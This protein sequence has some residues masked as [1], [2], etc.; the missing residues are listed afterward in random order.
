M[1]FTYNQID[2]A[3]C[4]FEAVPAG[5]DSGD[6]L[7]C[8]QKALQAVCLNIIVDVSTRPAALG[9]VLPHM[10]KLQK[11]LIGQSKAV[12]IK[13]LPVAIEND[14]LKQLTDLGFKII[15]TSNSNGAPSTVVTQD[16]VAQS[17]I[18]A[19]ARSAPSVPASLP[20]ASEMESRLR[21]IRGRLAEMLRRKRFLDNEKKTYTERLKSISKGLDIDE[22]SK[23]SVQQISQMEALLVKMKEEK[24]LLLKRVDETALEKKN[25]EE[26]N[27]KEMVDMQAAHKKKKET[28][29][30]KLAE[31]L[32][33]KEKIQ[34]DN[35]RKAELRTQQIAALKKQLNPPGT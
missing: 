34:S 26:K 17:V 1:G 22:M 30:K 9:A 33:K 25:A 2:N 3:N 32:K 18:D 20:S 7:L 12:T 19:S 11:V 6:F 35:K 23:D 27:K 8:I 15:P 4:Q 16:L 5:D 10:M 14:F 21:D 24:T 31:V 28:S 29:E 13:G